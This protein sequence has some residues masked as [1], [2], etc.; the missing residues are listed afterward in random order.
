MAQKALFLK[1]PSYRIYCSLYIIYVGFV[2]KNECITV[3]FAANVQIY[4]R[5]LRFHRRSLHEGLTYNPA[6]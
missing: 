5:I 3:F 6:K 2:F 1:D 4:S